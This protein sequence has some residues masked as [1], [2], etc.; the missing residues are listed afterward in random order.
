MKTTSTKSKI[1]RTISTIAVALIIA[2]LAQWFQRTATDAVNDSTLQEMEEIGAQMKLSMES[3]I[4]DG[5]EE[6]NHLAQYIAD[7]DITKDNV[8]EYFATQSQ[9]QEFDELYYVELDGNG[10]SADGENYNFADGDTFLSA[11]DK[12][13]HIITPN[14]ETVEGEM[15]FAITVPITKED[16]I[17]GYLVGCAVMDGFSE[18]IENA[19]RDRGAAF[20]VNQNLEIL[21][22]SSDEHMN[23][24]DISAEDMFS[25]GNSNVENALELLEQQETSSFLYQTAEEEKVLYYTKIENTEWVLAINMDVKAINGELMSAV[26]RLTMISEGIYWFLILVICYTAFAQ[27]RS[28]KTLEQTAFY[29]VLTGLPNMT[30]LR[31]EMQQILERNRG[32]RYTILK[33]DIENFR[34]INDLFSYE[35]GNRILKAVKTY[36]EALDEPTLIMARVGTDEF[37]MFA[38]TDALS[39]VEKLDERAVQHF[40]EFVTE[41]NHHHLS[42]KSGRY[43]IPKGETD[44]EDIINKV[45][46]AH[47][48]AKRTKGMTYCDYDDSFK[49]QSLRDAELTNKMKPALANQEFQIYLQPKFSAD[50]NKLVGAEALVR[51]IESDGTMIYPNDFI[52]LFER[53]GFIV[54][55]DKYVLENVCKT[56][57][58]WLDDGCGEITISVNCSRLNLE[59]PFFVDGVVAIADKY[60]VPHECIEIE[61]TESTT[62]E[63]DT[64]IEELFHELHENRFKISIDDFGAGYSSLGML[65]NLHVDTLKMDRSFF[66]GGKNARRNDMLIDSIVKM[67][68]NLGMYVVAEGIETPEQIELL[69]SMNCDAIQ[70]YVYEKPMPITEFEAKYYGFMREELSNKNTGLS[71]MQSINDAKYANSFVPCGI[72]ITEMDEHFTMV[73]ANT[74]FFDIVGYTK[75]ELRK[76]FHNRGI[77]TIHPDDRDDAIQAI[78]R[79]VTEDPTGK[80]DYT[81]RLANKDYGY[82]MVQL[83]GRVVKNEIGIKRCYLSITDISAYLENLRELQEEKNFN[84]RIAELTNSVFFDY[85]VESKTIR[86]SKNFADRFQ[87][88]DIIEGFLESEIG[89]NMFPACLNLLGENVERGENLRKTEGELCLTMPSGEPIWYLFSLKD[90]YDEH[91]HR[92]RTV[93]KMTEVLGHKLEMDILKVKSESDSLAAVYNELATERYIRSYLRL[94][95]EINETGAFFVIDLENFDRIEK[96]FGKEF[97]EICLRDIGNVLRNM[98]RSSDIIGRKENDKFFVFINNYRAI[99][100]VEKKAIELCEVLERTYEKDGVEL[101]VT[102]RIGISLY[103]DHGSDFDSVYQKADAA[104]EQIKRDGESR[105]SISDN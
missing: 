80:L 85:D 48:M 14:K 54:E 12:E 63:S 67:S 30:R 45:T 93:G 65:K 74:G 97:G 60:Q 62:I 79:K 41:L 3:V 100:F 28:Y 46:L 4:N 69:R 58:G 96:V 32:E 36:G 35:V 105:I 47:K 2:I 89:R 83:S 26:D 73:E 1:W 103:P 61:L 15:K 18:I 70:G 7:N 23:S 38:K 59:T 56:M 40:E 98:F 91:H 64:A 86:F 68:H 51:W 101:K 25:L 87:I 31:N 71:L 16:V 17:Q 99:E 39:S 104:L 55:L 6:V 95:T 19:T 42:F 72:L 43:H 24:S 50:E 11:L 57:R 44:V 8:V 90:V 102:P 66:V 21:F 84:A 88:P 20:L 13:S 94:A 92:C 77:D 49:K 81:C 9:T 29:D 82:K 10:I 75:E 33:T 78:A 22:T 76:T 52:P 5:V 34:V 37:I 53:N 27:Y